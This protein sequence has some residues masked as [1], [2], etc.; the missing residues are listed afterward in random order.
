MEPDSLLSDS[1]H[2]ALLAE[3]ATLR[4]EIA[5]LREMLEAVKASA[6][7]TEKLLVTLQERL[8]KDSRNTSKPPNLSALRTPF[9]RS[10]WP[11]RAD[12]TAWGKG[13][14]SS[15]P[16]TLTLFQERTSTIEETPN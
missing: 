12:S 16:L 2:L 11:L 5:G 8:G 1:R 4:A 3:N 7:R 10:W 15:E 14:D 9:F 13:A 6:E